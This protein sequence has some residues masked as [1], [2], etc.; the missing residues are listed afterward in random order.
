VYAA[1]AAAV[2]EHFLG[3][4]PPRALVIESAR[5]DGARRSYATWQQAVTENEDARVW[6]GIHFRTGDT[7]GSVL[8]RRVAALGLARM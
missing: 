5:S 3:P 7:A 6:A 8:G 4:E 1:A 2:L